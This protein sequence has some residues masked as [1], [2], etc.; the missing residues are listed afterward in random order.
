MYLRFHVTFFILKNKLDTEKAR[1][2]ELMCII[3]LPEWRQGKTLEQFIVNESGNGWWCSLG[4]FTRLD[5][6]H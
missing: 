6:I 1:I 3:R 2:N 4:Y 5:Y